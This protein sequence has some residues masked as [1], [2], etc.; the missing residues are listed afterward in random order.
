M[1]FTHEVQRKDT[2]LERQLVTFD[3]DVVPTAVM[4]L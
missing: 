4:S 3:V 1:N 2:V